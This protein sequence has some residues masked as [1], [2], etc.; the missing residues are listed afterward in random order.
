[1]KVQCAGRAQNN[2]R[3]SDNFR[4]YC[5]YVRPQLYLGGHYV[6]TYPIAKLHLPTGT[7][8]THS[9]LVVYSVVESLHC[10][11]TCQATVLFRWLQALQG[12]FSRN[13]QEAAGYVAMYTAYLHSRQP[14]SLLN[15]TAPF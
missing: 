13:G 9:A 15:Q 12:G 2:S 5:L 4:A 1:M 7:F 10:T 6:Q 11:T 14:N 8:T 3:T